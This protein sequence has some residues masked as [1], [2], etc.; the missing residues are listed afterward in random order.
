METSICNTYF[1]SGEKR[2]LKK[3]D[4]CFGDVPLSDSRT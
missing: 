3:Y 2:N 4:K 1:L